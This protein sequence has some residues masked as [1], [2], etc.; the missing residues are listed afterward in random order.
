MQ[1]E[2]DWPMHRFRDP[3]DRHHRAREKRKRENGRKS[4]REK[5]NQ[6]RKA[7]WNGGRKWEVMGRKEKRNRDLFWDPFSPRSGSS[8]ET[9]HFKRGRVRTDGR[10]LLLGYPWGSNINGANFAE[11]LRGL[12]NSESKHVQKFKGSRGRVLGIETSRLRL[13]TNRGSIFFSSRARIE[14]KFAKTGKGSRLAKL[15]ENCCGN[16]SLVDPWEKGVKLPIF[17]S[18]SSCQRDKK[19]FG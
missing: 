2:R 5:G 19:T 8:L 11:N 18:S 6:R 1:L 14:R 13:Q 3:K 10:D 15:L 16:K 4:Q 9:I 12:S 7:R 17:Y